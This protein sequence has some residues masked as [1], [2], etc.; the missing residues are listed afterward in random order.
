MKIFSKFGDIII[1]I[2][3]Y[4]GTIVVGIIHLP[5]T[6]R[7]LDL[8]RTGPEKIK[9]TVQ[10]IDTDEIG[11]K[12]S[13]ITNKV[14]EKY[15]EYS[16]KSSKKDNDELSSTKVIQES[17]SAP[18]IVMEPEDSDIDEG[19]III[20]NV[21]FDSKEKEDNVLKLQIAS[22][23]FLVA[24]V[25]LVFHFIS[26]YIYALVGVLLGAFI[27]Y[28]LY[29]KIK[30]MY[31]QDFNAYRDFFLLYIVVGI[32]LVLVGGNSSITM[33]F[34]FQFFPSF[35]LLIFAVIGV[36]A[37]FLLFRIRY[38]RDYTYGEII[39]AGNNTSHVKVD[40]DIRS[41]VK[42]DIYIVENNGY[43]VLD[44]EMVKLEID[45]SIFNMKGNR[46]SKIIGKVEG[47]N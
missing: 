24:S 40:Y 44:Q 8:K 18:D 2:F 35:S 19:A 1:T 33:A 39:E 37:V 16:D 27:Y 6:I 43:D 14:D 26:F 31:P 25:I 10:K 11:E 15:S 21:K 5:T 28:T 9:E 41:N 34:P 45:G 32:V 20:K 46:P 47:F 29:Y 38:H 3:S 13:H 17:V 30:L 42:P 22:G 23:A 36:A 4:T 7:K 12:L